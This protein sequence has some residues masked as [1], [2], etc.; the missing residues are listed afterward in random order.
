[1]IVHFCGVNRMRIGHANMRI[2]GLLRQNLNGTGTWTGTRNLTKINGFLD[3][4]LSFH[5]ATGVGLGLGLGT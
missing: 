1:M 2:N 3:I 4:M 5:T